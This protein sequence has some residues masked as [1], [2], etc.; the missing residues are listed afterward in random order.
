[1][2]G[3]DACITQSMT[4]NMA[5][6]LHSSYPERRYFER[7]ANLLRECLENGRIHFSASVVSQTADS[8]MRV[9]VLPNGRLNLYTVDELVRSSFH[10]LA[11]DVFNQI[12]E[13]E[14]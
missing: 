13:R 6:D 7:G 11:S 12:H 8:I 4:I 5:K 10:M 1:M 14:E 3:Q 2:Q 9:R